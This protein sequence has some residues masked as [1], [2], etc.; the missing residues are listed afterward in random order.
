[1]KDLKTIRNTSTVAQS[2]VFKGQQFTLSPH[3][4]QTYE[5]D[6]ADKF[7]EFCSPVVVDV[8][9][10]SM[11][12]MYAPELIA[13]TVWL[14]NVTGNPDSPST[15]TVTKYMKNGSLRTEKVSMPNPNHEPRS[16]SW[17]LKGGHKQYTAQD[18]GL[19]QLSL[20]PRMLTI[21]P[22]KR[23]PFAS[24]EAEFFMAN[25]AMT[26][27]RG[28]A[29]R[30]RAPSDFEPD[31]T[32]KLAEM[33]AF[34]RLT[35]PQA[36]IGP[37]DKM[38]AEQAAREGWDEKKANEELRKAK[39]M[40]MRRLYFRLVDPKYRLPTRKEF[41]E[42]LTGKSEESVQ[43]EEL[44]ALLAQADKSIGSGSRKLAATK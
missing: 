44:S 33:R 43:K 23:R 34:L 9:A 32:W 25:D 29:I 30:S 14:A 38:L 8:S 12:S 39:Q 1:M 42:F 40:V 17:E 24:E 4:E 15:V 27:V 11:G 31:M 28:A 41:N 7:L 35:D 18:G 21:P 5:I 2:I 37:D 36:D 16:L 19:V 3:D 10:D 26:E 6:V 13:K 22:F 20:T